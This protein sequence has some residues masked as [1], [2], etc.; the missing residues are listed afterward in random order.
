MGNQQQLSHHK[1]QQRKEV[2]VPGRMNNNDDVIQEDAAM[3]VG[4]SS[5]EIAAA[6]S[7]PQRA[8]KNDKLSNV[9]SILI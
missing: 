4:E 6:K 7:G 5:A 3:G 8:N 1:E 2:H 9:N